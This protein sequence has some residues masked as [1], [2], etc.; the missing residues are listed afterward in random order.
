MALSGSALLTLGYTDPTASW[1]VQ[2][3]N[4]ASSV[5]YSHHKQTNKNTHRPTPEYNQGP[6]SNCPFI[7][8][9]EATEAAISPVYT[10]G[11]TRAVVPHWDPGGSSKHKSLGCCVRVPAS[12]G[13]DGVWEENM[14]FSHVSRRCRSCRSRAHTLK[15]IFLLLVWKSKWC[16]I[17]DL[18]LCHRHHH[19]SYKKISSRMHLNKLPLS[20]SSDK[21]ADDR[22]GEGPLQKMVTWQ[23][24]R[25][26][27]SPGKVN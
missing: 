26:V 2:Q 23:A 24:Y 16:W 21:L 13:P 5:N 18:L 3:E 10:V 11:D 27:L 19:Q 9:G 20:Q 12:V 8:H 4:T 17:N 1:L 6:K 14:H 22:N 15:T 7:G 25:N